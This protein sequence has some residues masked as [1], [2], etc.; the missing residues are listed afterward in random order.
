MTTHTVTDDIKKRSTWGIV[1]GCLT[2]ALGLFLIVYPLAAGTITTVLLGWAMIFVGVAQLIF[3]LQS[4]TVG[5][6]FWKIALSL[7]YGIGGIA[8]VAAP[9]Q[10]LAALT[11]IVATVLILEGVVLAVM[12][13]QLRPADGWGWILADAAGSLLVGGLIIAGWPSSSVWA[14]GTLVGASVFMSGVSKIRI[15]STIRSG[16]SKLGNFVRGAA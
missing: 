15:A 4:Q 14:I 5:S 3:A 11:G 8:V 12:A 6:F 1:M 16:A 2:A 7:L 10:G 9:M 13:F